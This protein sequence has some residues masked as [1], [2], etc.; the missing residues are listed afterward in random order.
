MFGGFLCSCLSAR[1]KNPFSA[2]LRPKGHMCLV[3]SRSLF[4]SS[5]KTAFTVTSRGHPL[6]FVPGLTQSLR[7]Y[8]RAQG[9]CA[10]SSL[11]LLHPS[12]W[13]P[14]SGLR[15]PWDGGRCTAQRTHTTPSV[16][17]S[18]RSSAPRFFA[19]K[20]ARGIRVLSSFGHDAPFYY[21]AV[22][23]SLRSGLTADFYVGTMSPHHKLS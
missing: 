11:S 4:S 3:A 15:P 9:Y 21:T 7:K 2:P 12:W 16:A 19:V 5:Y 1:R 10:R 6:S 22:T 23:S 8:L 18:Q 14:L 20:T 13:C 17:S